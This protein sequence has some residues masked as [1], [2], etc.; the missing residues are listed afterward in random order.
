MYVTRK[1]SPLNPKQ[2]FGPLKGSGSIQEIQFF[3]HEAGASPQHDLF[4][5]SMEILQ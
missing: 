5:N 1:S 4:F 3:N 2:I